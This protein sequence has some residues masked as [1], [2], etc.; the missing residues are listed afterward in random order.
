[1]MESNIEHHEEFGK[2]SRR[3]HGGRVREKSR[4]L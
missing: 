1:M 3:L 4:I 2:G